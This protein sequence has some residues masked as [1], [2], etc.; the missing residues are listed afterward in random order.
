SLEVLVVQRRDQAYYML[1]WLTKFQGVE[2]PADRPPNAD[3]A[4]AIAEC[5]IQLPPEL[6]WKLNNTIEEL[7]KISLHGL[8]AWQQSP[9]L[10]GE[11]FLVLDERL[12][13]ELCGYHLRY[14]QC[15]GMLSKKIEEGDTNAGKNV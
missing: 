5:S 13:T 11:L 9:W 2:I 15:Y 7:E 10:K 3:H 4:R 8:S 1:P 6:C 14:D 12:S